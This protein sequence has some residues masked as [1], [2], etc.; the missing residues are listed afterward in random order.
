MCHFFFF[1][2]V[3]FLC[4]PSLKLAKLA[5]KWIYYFPVVVLN[6]IDSKDSMNPTNIVVSY[7]C[8]P[9]IQFIN[10]AQ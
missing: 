9:M 1:F 8:K 3:S 6:K 7:I 2:H 5:W 10:Q 4:Y